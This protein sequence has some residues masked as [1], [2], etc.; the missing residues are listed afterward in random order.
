M[1]RA[2]AWFAE[3]SVAANLLMVIILVAGIITISNVKKEIFPEMSLD[4]ISI[5]VPY[6]GAA[7]EEVEEGVCVRI[8]EAIQGLE[9]IKKITSTASEGM[10]S[11]MVEV[12][13]SHDTRELLDDVKSRVD[14]IETF[15]DETE[16]PVIREMIVRNQV[17]NVAISGE[18]DEITLKRLGEQVRD[19]ITALPGITNVDLATARP[20]E[21][22]IEVSEEALRR[23]QLTFDDVARAVRNTSLDLPGGSVKTASGEILL[24][25]KGQAYIGEEFARIVLLSR[26]DGTRLTVGDVATVVDGFAETDQ[27]A[28]FN[29]QPAVLVQVFRVGDQNA[30]EVADT[31]KQYVSQAQ[32]RMPQGISLTVWLDYSDFLR[33]RTELLVRNGYTGL[34]LLFTVLALF[35]K[36]RLAIWV[37]V[38]I[39]VSFLGAMALMPS[40]DLSVN[41]LSL[42]AFILVLGIVVDDAIVVGESIHTRHQAGESGLTGSIRGTYQVM[43]PVVFAVLTTLVAFSPLLFMPG[44]MGKFFRVIPLIVMPVLLFSLLESLFILPAHLSHLRSPGTARKPWVVSRGWDRFQGIFAGGLETFARKFYRR[45]LEVSLRWRYLTVAVGVTILTISLGTV[46]AG[47]LK[48]VFFPNVESDYVIADLTMPLGVP[49]EETERAARRIERAALQ[50]KEQ[51]DAESDGTLGSVFRQIFTSIGEQPMLAQQ[52]RFEGNAAAA[53][54]SHLAEVNIELAPSEQRTLSSEEIARRWRELTGPIPDAVD[55]TFNAS[56][57]STGEAI[58]IQFA[59]PRIEELQQVTEELKARLADYPGVYNVS[60]SFREGKE[61]IRLSIKPVAE[62]LGLTLSDLARQ[63]RQGFYGEEAQRIQRGRD[64]VRI[65]VRYPATERRSL[66]DLESMRIR[67][68]EGTE[69]PFSTVAVAD[70][71]RGY[72]SINRVDRRRTINITADVDSSQAN[73]NEIMAEVTASVL[74]SIL[75]NHP[76]ITYSLEG[77]QNEQRESFQGLGK[78]FAFAVLAIYALLAIPFKSY[79]QPFIVLSAVPFG[80]VG[81]IW[82]H[83][84]MG[85]DLSVLS[86]CGMVALTGVVVNDSLIL[87]DYVNRNVRTGIPLFEAVRTAGVARFRPIIL[88]SLTTFAGLTPLLLETS[89]Q[90][91]V[92]IP[93][94]V[95]LGFGVLFATLITLLIVPCSYTILEDLKVLFARIFWGQPREE[96]ELPASAVPSPEWSRVPSL[97]ESIPD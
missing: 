71:G 17:I 18:A 85:M 21:I 36:L 70:Y 59:G 44:F 75:S 2:V 54:E 81:A 14:A 73:E 82:G 58:N 20:Y 55:L 97:T 65:M 48:L 61:E 76:Q 3:N 19:E 6:L 9:G 67:T 87:V 11:V 29:G 62:Q 46:G 7:P 80:L 89:V 25:T 37:S 35:L 74:P 4:M 22:S 47:W 27:R 94:A 95:S 50:L 72:A 57:F 53:S 83:L 78:A 39:P 40:L 28:R 96:E 1:K 88:T 49:A 69:V 26:P 91:Q 56:I 15:P 77:T 32:A 93:M 38:G 43:V 12:L 64:D 51:I 90:A 34:L 8:E 31:V 63:V 33:S 24:R 68:P 42:F 41:M 52:Q 60:D 84:I 30:I 45:G 23:H 92:L 66:G 79:V 13:P 16:K 10:G 5:R 86:L